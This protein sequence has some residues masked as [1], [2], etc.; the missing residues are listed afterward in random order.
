[1]GHWLLAIGYCEATARQRLECVA[2]S[3]FSATTTVTAS[4]KA[5]ASRTHSKRS[6]TTSI[7][8]QQS[9]LSETIQLRTEENKGNEVRP[10][11]PPKL[12]SSSGL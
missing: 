2:R 6:A 4:A 8:L 1:M 7:P 10:D 5:P 12:E 3:R 9:K 11:F